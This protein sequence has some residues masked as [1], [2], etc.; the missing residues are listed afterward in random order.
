MCGLNGP[1]L[2]SG[3]NCGDRC[4]VRMGF[5]LNKVALREVL[6]PVLRFPASFTVTPLLHIHR[7]S[8]VCTVATVDVAVT[9]GQP[10]S[11]S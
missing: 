11:V 10:E 9:E 1:C 8:R 7:P 5:V 4:S 3:G 2:S 6:L